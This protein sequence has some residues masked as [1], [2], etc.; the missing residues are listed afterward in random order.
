LAT[1]S[2]E[3]LPGWGNRPAFPLEPDM[4]VM[5][6]L[7]SLCLDFAAHH[8]Q[9][10]PFQDSQGL[11]GAEAFARRL[12]EPAPE[13]G[14]PIEEAL[15]IFAGAVPFSMNTAGPGYMAFIPGGGLYASALADFLACCTNRYVGIRG[16]APALAQM[17]L[18]VIRWFCRW[19]GYDAQAMGT[20]TSGGS[21]ANFSALVTARRSLLPENFLNGTIYTSLQ[22]HHSVS[23]AALLAGFPESAIRTVRCDAKLRIDPE[24][25]LSRIEDDRT[26]GFIPFMIVA[27]AGTTNTG[28]VDP[29]PDTADI[30]RRKN[31]WLHVDAAYGGFFTLTTRGMSILRGIECADS[32]T[33]DPHKGLFLPYGTGCLLVKNGAQLK[34]AH[35]LDASYLKDLEGG[36]TISFAD[37]SSELTRDF[38]GL[39][40]WLPLKLYGVE[41][42]RQALDEKLDLARHAYEELI[43]ST[44]FQVLSPPDLSL[45]AFRYSP[46]K[47][48]IDEF[49]RLLL[50]AVN[51]ER[52]VFL[53]STILDGRFTLRICVLNFRTHRE[54]VDAALESLIRNARRIEQQ[55]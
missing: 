36:D 53:S 33:L 52:K 22:A 48:D 21:I 7:G 55:R 20:L 9:S 37:Y 45:V 23:K 49:N 2:E 5:R 47:G 13:T 54:H 42:F 41:A 46:K 38:R 16:A 1:G 31:M 27:N 17:E 10:L 18:N 29:L 35:C 43:E 14:T 6:R 3:S 32:I 50:A 15:S 39:R 28:S 24:D 12:D 51:S 25:L 4:R 30:A 8:I 34:A 26:Q 40:V 19:M 11:E 44:S